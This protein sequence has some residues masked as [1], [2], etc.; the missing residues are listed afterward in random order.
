MR[1][2]LLATTLLPAAALADGLEIV[3]DIQPIHS[4]VAQVT[5]GISEPTV[6]VEGVTDAHSF[7]FRPSQARA[8]Q[9]ADVIFWVGET[10]TRWLQEPVDTLGDEAVVVEFLAVK[11]WPALPFRTDPAFEH[12]H[13]DHDDDDNH[14]HDHD[15]DDHD[16]HAHED[17]DDD[18]HDHDHDD[19]SHDDHDHDDHDDHAHEDHDDDHHDHDH[20][21]IDPH[22]WL[23]PDVASAWLAI[24]ANTLSE[25]DPDNAAAYQ[26]NATTAQ[27]DLVTLKVEITAMLEPVRGRPY[28]VPHDSL[29]YFETAFDMPAAGAIALYDATTPGPQRVR[30]VQ[31]RI[32]EDN[33]ACVLTDP[34]VTPVWA[35]LVR[36]GTEAKTAMADPLG[37]AI[38]PGPDHHAQT[39]RA[40]AGAL[41][42]C[43]SD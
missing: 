39:L 5:A 18:H 37:G 29:Q 21:D 35:D 32:A 15:D 9:E 23:S 16:D 34:Q 36:E 19:H 31:D 40:M 3:T 8:L 42:A 13:D 30:A 27:A 10:M 1:S 41:V 28:I 4:L 22:A 25:A 17:H 6:L 7:S 20:G 11:G 24:I 14:G 12:A 26:A 38:A 43:L 2:I 33:I